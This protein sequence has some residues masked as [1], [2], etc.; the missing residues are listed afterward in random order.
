[1]VEGVVG[2]GAELQSKAFR[3]FGRL[4]DRHV[5]DVES[6]RAKDVPARVGEGTSTCLDE[7]S[8]GILGNIADDVRVAGASG[9]RC[10][11][12]AGSPPGA[13]IANRIYDGA[14]AGFGVGI[15]NGAIARAVAVGVGIVVGQRSYGLPRF[16]DVGS[17]PLPAVGQG[18][19]EATVGR[20]VR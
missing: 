16:R 6:R 2:V 18:L 10:R 15:N 3:D 4:E 12:D 8:R 1:M 5:P 20:N 9:C 17:A 7:S 11:N 13:I 14:D 19:Q